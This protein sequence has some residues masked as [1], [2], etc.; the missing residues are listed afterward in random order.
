MQTLRPTPTPAFSVSL[1]LTIVLAT[2]VDAPSAPEGSGVGASFVIAPVF[3]LVG[4]EGPALSEGQ[5]DALSD[6]FDRV[7]RFRMQVRRAGDNTL[8]LDTIIRVTPGGDEYDL[9]V[10]I[11]ARNNEQFL[12]TLTALEG[13]TELFRA[14]NIPA[15]ASP[16]SAP[17]GAPAP[18][19]VQIPLVYSG[20]GATATSVT[21]GPT[22]VVLAPGG[23]ATVGSSVLDAGGAVIAGVPVAWTTTA[24]GV[25]TVSGGAVT[26]VG[27]GLA[28][29]TATT[30]TGLASSATVYVVGGELA[31]VEGGTLKVRSVAAG[32]PT[33]RGTGASQPAWSADGGRLFYVSDGVVQRSGGGA[34]VHGSWPSV[35]PDGTKLAVE[36]GGQIFFANDDGTAPTPGPTGTTPAWS[37]GEAVVVGGGSIERVRA[38][39]SG[40]TTVVAGQA[41]LPALAG[42]GRVAWLEEGAL[43]ATGV[44]GALVGGATGRAT[45]S[46]S[47][48]WLVVGTGSGLVLVPSDGSAE[49]VA[50]PGLGGAG[51]PAFKP[52]GSLQP[53]APVSVSGFNPAPPRPGQPV[54]ILGD[55]FDWIIPANN[56]VIW[57]TRDGTTASTV[58]GVTHG[59][60]ATVMPRNVVEGQVRVETRASSALLTFVPTVGAL[61]VTARTPWG[62]PVEGVGLSL[63][64]PE[65][66]IPGSTDAA[67]VAQFDG[68]L[69]GSYTLSISAHI[70]YTLSG[71]PVRTL[72]IG[73]Q[74]SELGLELTPGIESV[75]LLSPEPT[76]AAGFTRGVSLVISGPGG[77]TIPQVQSLAWRSLS[78]ELTVTPETGLNATLAG[79]FA[80]EGPGT[81]V[82]EVDVEGTTYTF[83]VTVTSAIRGSVSLDGGA[84]VPDVTVQVRNG[85]LLVGEATT[86]PDG[87]Y[88]VPG[89]FRGTYDV[90][91]AP[92]EDLLPVPAGQ[93]VMLDEANPTG[94]ADFAMQSFAGLDV[95][96]RTP[97]DAPV[98]GV[99]VSLRD[100]DAA[101]VAQ[102]ETDEDGVL[103]L[104]RLPSG[105]FTLI[106]TVP[107]G[108]NLTGNA[109]REIVLAPGTQILTLEVTPVIQAL[110]TLPDEPTVEV[111]S[112]IGIQ[113][114]PYDAQGNVIPQVQGGGW[115]R[116]SGHLAVG[117]SG[118]EG[119]IGGVYPSAPGEAQFGLELNGRVY[120]L[121]ATVTSRI[122]GTVTATDGE[123]SGPAPG[124]KVVAQQDGIT[125]A[126]TNA[127]GDGSYVLSGLLAGTYTV[128][129][130]PPA[131]KS[132]SPAGQSVTLGAG[133]PVGTASFVMSQLSPGGADRP[134][135]LVCGSVQR[136]VTTFFPAGSDLTL[137]SGNCS[138][139]ANTQALLITRY[140]GS[141]ISATALQDYLSAGG[142]VLT[143]YSIS[144][145]VWNATFGT[146]VPPGSSWG[147][148]KDIIPSVVQFSPSD[149]FWLNNTFQPLQV[150]DTGCGY[151]VGHFPGLTPLLGW[152]SN[153]VSVGYRDVGAGRLWITDFDWQDN[154]VYPYADYTAGLMGYMLSHRR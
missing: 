132:V 60:I 51:D 8:V 31:Y 21:V 38:D 5:E 34:L 140:G 88:A 73:A 111:G 72:D 43:R 81:S 78:P 116:V 69:P 24:P 11:D 39:G 92:V 115:F 45:W 127:T 9:S 70:G 15:T 68:L 129:A 79:V 84:P 99:Q 76:L 137:V 113:V 56:Q 35:S 145:L 1:L 63:A 58:L 89:L 108:F 55:G 142:I 118:L 112:S 147:A 121:S 128:K 44:A 41:T 12:V 7:D 14:E 133:T 97:W 144:H 30:P 96:A 123:G 82:L 36:R 65:G 29:V 26:A 74:T 17:P 25:A 83:P 101:V 47:G 130:I 153:G 148:C 110:I 32:T 87:A 151:A 154:E 103:S 64:G 102:G 90:A 131:G 4:P 16:A 93:T 59:A 126:E 2:C 141:G 62:A 40:R 120:A 119:Q 77:V 136:D 138:P 134:H 22:Q 80:G 150:N 105:T 91:P 54:Q 135:V 75:G 28:T 71:D 100:A 109:S 95:S 114:I 86:G 50:L 139:D 27:E 107:G 37:D 3:S 94:T 42:D 122:V 6:A 52:T 98:R 53:T 18:T 48:L 146:S 33:E 152:A 46:P 19:P 13:D 67:G 57:P 106:I 143:E 104:A 61:D 66:T 124:T 85:G 125:R 149:P 10:P 23:S 49:A 20:P 117:G